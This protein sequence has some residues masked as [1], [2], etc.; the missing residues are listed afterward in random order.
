M[1]ISAINIYILDSRIVSV[2]AVE[3]VVRRT[4]KFVL[5]TMFDP[6]WGGKC[7]VGGIV[8]NTAFIFRAFVATP[9]TLSCLCIFLDSI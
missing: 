9:R 4:A 8:H 6:A 7:Y 5:C 3:W 2:L 1:K